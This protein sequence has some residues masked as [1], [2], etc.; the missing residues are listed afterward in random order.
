MTK[1]LFNINYINIDF[2]YHYTCFA[3]LLLWIIKMKL[4]RTLIT[5]TEFMKIGT[6]PNT[7]CSENIGSIQKCDILI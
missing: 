5:K 6:K 4:S 1:V 7:H 3:K 2:C